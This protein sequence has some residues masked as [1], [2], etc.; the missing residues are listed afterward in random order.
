MEI[1]KERNEKL[2][3]SPSE[4]KHMIGKIDACTIRE[5]F[6]CAVEVNPCDEDSSIPLHS[7]NR[8]DSS[9]SIVRSASVRRST[10]RRS[11]TPQPLPPEQRSRSTIISMTCNSSNCDNK[12]TPDIARSK[13]DIGDNVNDGGQKIDEENKIDDNIQPD[14]RSQFIKNRSVFEL[15]ML[16]TTPPPFQPRSYIMSSNRFS[17]SYN[18]DKSTDSADKTQP[19]RRSSVVHTSS[20]SLK[21]LFGAPTPAKDLNTFMHEF[22]ENS[23]VRTVIRNSFI[24]DVATPGQSNRSSVTEAGPGD[25]TGRGEGEVE[26][27]DKFVDPRTEINEIEIA[28]FKNISKDGIEL[29]NNFLEFVCLGVDQSSFT[30][31]DA[32]LDFSSDKV[33]DPHKNIM[34]LEKT[35]ISILDQYSNEKVDGNNDNNNDNNDNNNTRDRSCMIE[36]ISDYCF[37][38]GLLIDVILKSDI[39]KFTSSDSDSFHIMQFSNL[40]GVPTYASCIVIT[41]CIPSVSDI[42]NTDT[43]TH[44]NTNTNTDPITST[45]NNSSNNN[46]NTNSNTSSNHNTNIIR[47]L[48]YQK[49]LF[50]KSANIIKKI[51]KQALLR[52]KKILSALLKSIPDSILEKKT[53]FYNMSTPFKFRGGKSSI[54]LDDTDTK[55]SNIGFG[56]VMMSRIKQSIGYTGTGVGVGVAEKE[57]NQKDLSSS[58]YYEVD[59]PISMNSTE[60]GGQF[61]SNK[62]NI[63]FDDEENRNGMF[64]DDDEEDDDDDDEDEDEDDGNDEKRLGDSEKSH[65]LRSKKKFGSRSSSGSGSGSCRDIKSNESSF[66]DNSSQKNSKCKNGNQ[67][68]KSD[69]NKSE[70][71]NQSGNESDGTI[72]GNV[73]R[74]IILFD[75]TPSPKRVNSRNQFDINSPLVPVMLQ[76]KEYSQRD[77]SMKNI[78]M[79]N[80]TEVMKFIN[81]SGGDIKRKDVNRDGNG[82]GNGNG[83]GDGDLKI[84]GIGRAEDVRYD[85]RINSPHV[86]E[87]G[88]RVKQNPV[89]GP[90][91]GRVGV[92]I[93]GQ[94]VKNFRPANESPNNMMD[95]TNIKTTM[96]YG[97]IQ[98]Q[99][100]KGDS[101]NYSNSSNNRSSSNN[102]NNGNNF[103]RTI[104]IDHKFKNRSNSVAT[105]RAIKE[106]PSTRPVSTSFALHRARRNGDDDSTELSENI[107]FRNLSKSND[108]DMQNEIRFLR[109]NLEEEKKKKIEKEKEIN[110][111]YTENVKKNKII[112]DW[113]TVIGDEKDYVLVTKKAYCILSFQPSHSFSFSVS[114]TRT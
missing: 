104:D 58:N 74:K 91:D 99:E 41:E 52:R 80:V 97:Q 42:K 64:D 27:V 10:F 102:G 51:F 65:S 71:T 1:K 69:K 12:S 13:S 38:A 9:S 40:A 61:E 23:P 34:L 19:S 90:N 33:L 77:L 92:E 35:Q 36:S 14:F 62:V 87:K 49:R 105:I 37:P 5:T 60:S 88:D 8:E 17:I 108:S 79:G 103:K 24:S 11:L 25:G 31:G 47:T 66:Y 32:A 83:D 4:M 50:I 106:V 94:S 57:K 85:D 28:T 95:C 76:K 84:E 75:K 100:S 44:T 68:D 112:K 26:E 15:D 3:F 109:N 16:T 29:E 55:P 67:H 21:Q 63:G 110:R 73:L 6:D 107:K 43:N 56:S 54:D 98:S 89:Q 20:P 48:L 46:T 78:S 70:E 2:L 45:D 39:E 96:K 93:R 59:T 86:T 101:R 81:R 72:E 18:A 53:T 113:L 22:P 30:K 114:T 7:T 82:N 111:Q